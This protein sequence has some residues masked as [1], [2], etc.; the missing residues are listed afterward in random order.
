MARRFTE[1]DEVA[2][3]GLGKFKN[4]WNLVHSSNVMKAFFLCDH[5]H[6]ISQNGSTAPPT[7]LQNT[8]A[9]CLI[10]D[11]E[12]WE[13]NV[14]Y[15]DVQKGVLEQYLKS[16][17]KSAIVN[18]RCNFGDIFSS[19]QASYFNNL[20]LRI[21]SDWCDC[22][23]MESKDVCDVI[24]RSILRLVKWHGHGVTRSFKHPP[25]STKLLSF[26]DTMP[27]LSQTSQAWWEP[28]SKMFDMPFLS[29]V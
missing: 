4:S 9:L 18:W 25:K 6:G 21:S 19:F 2:V 24:L 15:Q 11:S 1:K 27:S 13:V 28:S 3:E 17:R 12:T 20:L 10:F 22:Q 7:K 29:N 23:W 26:K 16:N 8:L 5:F 14:R